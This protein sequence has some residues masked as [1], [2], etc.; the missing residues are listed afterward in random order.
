[1]D[2]KQTKQDFFWDSIFLCFLISTLQI[3]NGLAFRLPR[4]GKL[5][6]KK[7]PFQW[8]FF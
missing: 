4:A 7:K 6:S 3:Q 2:K 8:A 1:V 5:A